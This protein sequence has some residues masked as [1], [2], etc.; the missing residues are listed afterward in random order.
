MSLLFDTLYVLAGLAMLPWWLWK[1]PRA[2][3]YRAGVKQRLGLAPELPA[4]RPRVWIHCASVGEAAVPRRLVE[5]I[6]RR[7]PRRDIVFSTNTNTGAGRL[8]ELY[9]DC[10]VFYM[11]LDV[12]FCS[13]RA[14]DRVSPDVVL[15]VELELWPNFLHQC[16]RRGIAVGIVSGRIGEGSRRL[17]RILSRLRPDMWEA[18]AVCC[19]R[20]KDDAAGFRRAGLSPDKVR[21]CGSLKYDAIQ[22]E[23]DRQKLDHLRRLFSIEPDAPVLVAGSTH[24]GE[25]AVVGSAYKALKLRHR[26]LRLVVAPRHVERATAA[27]ATLKARGLPVVRKTLLESR[28]TAATSDAVVVLDTI[29]ELAAC[30]ALAHCAFVGR[31]LLPPGGGQ[32]MMEPAG[33]GVPVIV[34]PHTGNFRPEMELLRREEAVLV[35]QDGT[36]L[37]KTVDR[38]LSDP[39]LAEKM[40][41]AG[42]RVISESQGAAQRTLEALEPLLEG[43]SQQSNRT[44]VRAP[45][46]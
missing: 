9:P 19:A 29:G 18:I 11:P 10:A 4:D 14:L 39:A 42:R 34:G 7:Y 21:N 23:P 22:T 25:E 12:S 26:K 38:L 44:P 30:Y 15:V 13:G 43:A 32:N 2:E 5:S 1:L 31:S 40:G 16:R 33:L 46:S 41:R 45:G 20:S 36:E 28:H 3:R 6:R 35:V 8:R 37:I 27:A 24:E 17:L